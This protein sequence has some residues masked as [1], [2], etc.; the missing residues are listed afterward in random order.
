[1]R[2]VYSIILLALAL[3][4]NDFVSYLKKHIDRSYSFAQISNDNLNS[5][6][7]TTKLNLGLLLEKSFYDESSGLELNTALQVKY[8]NMKKAKLDLREAYVV[9]NIGETWSLH[10]GREL[11]SFSNAS[12]LS[13][14]SFA[15]RLDNAKRL[16]DND[17]ILQDLGVDGL[18]LNYYD[19]FIASLYIYNVSEKLDK[20]HLHTVLQLSKESDKYIANTYLIDTGTTALETAFHINANI[21]DELNAILESSLQENKLSYTVGS[22]YT[23]TPAFSISL[24]K[25]FR[26]FGQNKNQG[27][28][29]RNKKAQDFLT[30]DELRNLDQATLKK[31]AIKRK[32]T[33]LSEYFKKLN[34]KNYLGLMLAYRYEDYSLRNFI[35]NNSDDGSS[36]AILE[37]EYPINQFRFYSRYITHFGNKNSEFG[38]SDRPKQQLQFLVAFSQ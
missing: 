11:F 23:P 8:L 5:K 36:Q 18:N 1:M 10:L 29:Y 38:S 24:E 4:A 7:A 16:Q 30:Q 35:L 6:S 34:S 2:I 32:S 15:R 26:S 13:L 19:D 14:A 25:S 17:R 22:T 27:L 3:S 37:L 21:N 12:L 31:L 28:T 9:Y 20:K 33:Y